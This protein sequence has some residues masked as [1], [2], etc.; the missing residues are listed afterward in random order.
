ITNKAICAS[1]RHL[2][3]ATKAMAGAVVLERYSTIEEALVV[4]SVLSAQGINAQLDCSYHAQNDWLIAQALGGIGVCLKPSDHAHAR[5]MINRAKEEA[6]LNLTHRWGEIGTPPRTKRPVKKW[7]F[8]ILY[9]AE[10]ISIVLYVALAG[11]L[12]MLE[13]K[14][15]DDLKNIRRTRL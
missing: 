14:R 8:P 5:D 3:R 2:R 15:L 9:L 4:Q 12:S 7:S 6:Y 11:V 13:S 1:G 10:P